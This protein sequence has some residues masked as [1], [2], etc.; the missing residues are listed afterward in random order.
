MKKVE[1]NEGDTGSHECSRCR[2]LVQTRYEL[3]TV[4]MQG[5]KVAVPDVL[6]AVC[7]QC[8]HTVQIPRQSIAQ[9]REVGAGK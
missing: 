1:W 8:D 4:Q 9:L 7:T 2:T 3:R 5:T 6:V